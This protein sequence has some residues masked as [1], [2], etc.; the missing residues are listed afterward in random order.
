V[1]KDANA[2]AAELGMAIGM[3]AKKLSI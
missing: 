2:T 3:T 1:I